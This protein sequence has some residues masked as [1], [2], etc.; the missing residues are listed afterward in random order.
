MLVAMS[1]Y[2]FIGT[3][4]IPH[5]SSTI[6]LISEHNCFKQSIFMLINS[7]WFA[8]NQS[9][10]RSIN[11]LCSCLLHWC[12]DNVCCDN[13][14]VSVGAKITRP[15][16]SH[17][18]NAKQGTFALCGWDVILIRFDTNQSQADWLLT[19]TWCVWR[20]AVTSGVSR[21]SNSAVHL[22]AAS[23]RSFPASPV[24]LRW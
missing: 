20:V 1:F 23:A 14:T 5:S 6:P 10:D 11:W 24:S 22:P 15:F 13:T 18:P 2:S 4:K 16:Y 9:I 3:N 21:S 19:A 7:Y 17:L 8:S 12:H